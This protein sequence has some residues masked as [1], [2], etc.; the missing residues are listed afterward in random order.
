MRQQFVNVLKS[1]ESGGGDPAV[2]RAL[3]G[4]WAR[5]KALPGAGGCKDAGDD[6][7]RAHGADVIDL[8]RWMAQ[9]GRVVRT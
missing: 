3:G 1:D 4:F 8:A 6:A 9:R 5:A 7:G 2:D